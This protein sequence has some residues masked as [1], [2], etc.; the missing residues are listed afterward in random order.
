ML[1]TSSS[2]AFGTGRSTK[3]ELAWTAAGAFALLASRGGNRIG[4]VASGKGG[5]LIPA[6]SGRAHTAAVLTALRTPPADGDAGDLA[7]AIRLVRKTAKRRGMA[8]VVSDFLGEPTWER[9]LRALT[10]RH[11]VIAVQVNDRRE[12]ELP[13]VGLIAVVDPE[14]GR[15]RVVDTADH[16]VRERY[17]ALAARRQTALTARLASTRRR[18]PPVAHRPRLGARRRP[19]RRPA[20]HPASHRLRC[21]PPPRQDLTMIALAFLAPAR[22]VLL[23]LP[24]ILAVAYLVVQARR[25]RY[26]LRFT[27]LDLLDEV[28]PDRPGWRRHLPAVVLLA[29][30]V[31]ATLAVARPAVAR[32]FSEPQRIVVLAVDTSLSMQATD[33]DPSRLD[34]AKAAVGDFLDTVPDGVAVGVV[35]FDSEARQLIQPTTNL[36]AV[37]R[38]IERADLGEGTAIGEAVFLALDSI[39]TASTQLGSDETRT[40]DS[41]PAGTIVLLSDGET[42]HGRPNDEA[43]AEAKARGIAV[44]TVAFGTDSGTIED[45][46]TGAQVPVPVNEA[47]LGDLARATGGQ[48]LQAETADELA[49]VYQDLG[50]NLQ[51]D[52]ERREVTDWFAGA[53]LLLLVL[54]ATGSLFWFGRLP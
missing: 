27:T 28:A 47:A 21:R 8:I 1:D 45:P 23:V 9:S 31:A 24:I 30:T 25:R 18:P 40:S 4:A 34:A 13:A 46:L 14:T 36:D 48:S 26:A 5:R 38:V 42:T 52:V 15:R 43:A 51:V 32:E 6:R 12:F 22:L 44:N 37:R 49:N 16:G 39:E 35:A 33:V 11:E 20:P 41:P 2:H 54:A 10:A 3:H 53:S 29:G 19:L 7:K 17:A 50:R